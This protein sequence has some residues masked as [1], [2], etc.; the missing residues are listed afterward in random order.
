MSSQS[1]PKEAPVSP[2]EALLLWDL[3]ITGEEPAMSKTK[4]KLRPSKREILVKKGFIDLEKRG[5]STHI[6]LTD[7]AWNCALD[8]L[9]VDGTTSTYAATALQ[10][11]IEKLKDYL[12]SHDISLSE[13]LGPQNNVAAG[14][15]NEFLTPEELEEK[16]RD[17]Y[18]KVSGGSYNVRVRL[19]ELRQHLDN[20]SRTEV[21]KIL[22][23]MQRAE[24]LVLMPLDDPQE[25]SP[26]DEEAAIDM[27]GPR[28]HILYMKG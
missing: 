24:Q 9:V 16:I 10:H 6:L 27:G 19:A 17:A 1:N 25:I 26:E 28:R 14:S 23:K 15:G 8:D 3:L 11:L 4:P 21:D 20:L 2:T 18:S 12:Q 13:F 7:K 22:S 5:S